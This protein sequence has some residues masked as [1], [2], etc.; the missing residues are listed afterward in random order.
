VV[1]GDK[2]EEAVSLIDEVGVALIDSLID[3]DADWGDEVGETEIVAEA[4]IEGEA[5]N[6]T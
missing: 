3:G 4:E 1:L 5:D 6:I 2:L